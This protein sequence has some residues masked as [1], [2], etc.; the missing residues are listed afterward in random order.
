VLTFPAEGGGIFVLPYGTTIAG[1]RAMEK[2]YEREKAEAK[3]L[4]FI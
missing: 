2:S 4:G 1:E 3:R